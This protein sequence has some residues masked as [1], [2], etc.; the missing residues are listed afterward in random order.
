MTREPSH[1]TT[2]HDMEQIYI[3]MIEDTLHF[4]IMN[5]FANEPPEHVLFY[6]EHSSLY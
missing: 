1:D 3:P 6:F 2:R 5:K 4:L